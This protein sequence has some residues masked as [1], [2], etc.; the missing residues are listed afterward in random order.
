[1]TAAASRRTPPGPEGPFPG[2]L[3]VLGRLELFV[4]V[5]AFCGVVGLV[6]AQ[7]FLR[8]L[9]DIG[10]VWVQEI[11]QLLILITYF[12]GTSFVFKTRHYLIIGFL[13][14]RFDE[15]TKLTLYLATQALTAAFCAM[16]FLELLGI[17]PNQLL[18]KT[19][20]LHIPRFYSS[21]PLMAASASMALTAL[22]YGVTAARLARRLGPGATLTA[23]EG[24]ANL[25][26]GY[27]GGTH[28]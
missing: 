16:L 7:V 14:E 23:I 27:Q 12:F 3:R 25:F 6:S 22:Y 26:P 18:M 1:M 8:Y 5:V 13:F 28:G 10:L 4:T 9:F 21:L 20:I 15:R 17:A 19:Y 2:A 11:S 24:A